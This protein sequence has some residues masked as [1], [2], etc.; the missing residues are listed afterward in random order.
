M[1]FG[2]VK[3]SITA[4]NTWTDWLPVAMGEK[5][6]LRMRGTFSAYVTVQAKDQD[7]DTVYYTLANNL[8]SADV[9]SSEKVAAPI[10]VRAGVAT[11]DFVSGAVDINLLKGGPI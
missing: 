3:A 6:E 7:S 8:T 1:S 11:G 10:F 2:N 9:Y 4:Q 5:F